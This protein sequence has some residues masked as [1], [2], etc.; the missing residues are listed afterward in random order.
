MTERL[1]G[2]LWSLE[3]SVAVFMSRHCTALCC[4]LQCSY[5]TRWNS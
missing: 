2:K 4:V 5:R 3:N 1:Q